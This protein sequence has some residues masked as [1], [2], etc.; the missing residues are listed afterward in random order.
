VA[1]ICGERSLR[2]AVVSEDDPLWA[3]WTWERSIP[4]LKARGH[5][6]SGLWTCPPVLARLRG[7]HI[8]RWYLNTFGVSTFV[9]L[10]AFSTLARLVRSLRS[11]RGRASASFQAL[12]QAEGIPY[13]ETRS[14]N[15]PELCDWLRA[16]E[17]DVLVITVGYILKEP[18]LSAPRLGI[19]NKHAALLPGH[20]GLLPYFWARLH[21]Q[22]QG[23]S[24]H[25]VIQGIDDGPVLYQEEVAPEAQGASM[26]SFYLHVFGRF[27]ALLT[28]A[29]DNLRSSCSVPYRP[30]IT[31][32]YF[33]LPTRQ[34]TL[35]FFEVGGQVITWHDVA[36]AV[37]LSRA[38]EP[39]LTPLTG[40][41][42]PTADPEAPA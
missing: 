21:G 9:K 5:T 12:A 27:P 35:R 16:T 19:I 32:S 10:A 13:R 41:G 36:Q 42:S 3:L 14:P 25:R 34:D 39:H 4:A 33:G 22:P 20:K 37:S 2:I 40:F 28:A 23:I 38:V 26:I 30:E 17:I 7:R 6:I 8:P 24:F 1:V 29:I 15:T 18:L 11:V 31:P